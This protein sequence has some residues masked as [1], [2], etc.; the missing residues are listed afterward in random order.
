MI[1]GVSF[2]A[3]STDP[4]IKLQD[5]TITQTQTGAAAAAPSTPAA[6]TDV[7]G[8]QFEGGK[9]QKKGKAGKVIAGLIATGAAVLAGLAI[10]VKT[11]KLSKIE[12]PEGETATILNKV[13][14]GAADIGQKVL[15]TAESLAT[16][17]KGLF[18]K[19]ERE[20]EITREPEVKVDGDAS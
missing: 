7:K 14:N 19:A 9:E 4:T 11:G 1:H 12:I 18:H 6:A 13:K 8:D 3:I 2:G 20:P 5:S 17:V 15:D 10:A 16:K